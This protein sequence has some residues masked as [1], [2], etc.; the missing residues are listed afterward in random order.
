MKGKNIFQVLLL[1]SIFLVSLQLVFAAGE[2]CVAN[3]NCASGEVCDSGSCVEFCVNGE[4]E[5]SD[6]VDNDGDGAYDYGG[7]CTINS[8][9][10]PC[11]A[12]PDGSGGTVDYSGVDGSLEECEAV[13]TP[14]NTFISGDQEC[15]SPLDTDET[16]DP[17]CANGVDDDSDGTTDFPFDEDCAEPHSES[18]AE[19]AAGAPAFAPEEEKGFF[20]KLWDF[21][22]FWRR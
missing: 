3:E 19:G 20:A 9:V 6:G 8:V 5:C 2:S 15:R 14:E 18:E 16:T 4:T 10:Y 1:L 21:L 11:S 7:S 22:F 17:V 13:C 12:L